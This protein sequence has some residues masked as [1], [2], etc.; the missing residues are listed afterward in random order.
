MDQD[1]AEVARVLVALRLSPDAVEAA[2]AAGIEPLI[3]LVV[4][5]DYATAEERYAA[6]ALVIRLEGLRRSGMPVPGGDQRRVIL[7]Q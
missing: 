5:T 3:R 2:T 1:R 7:R 6:Q 4:G